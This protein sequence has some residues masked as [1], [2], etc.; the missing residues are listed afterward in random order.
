MVKSGW[1]EE[2]LVKLKRLQ[3]GR[4][5]TKKEIKELL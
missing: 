1:E 4:V 5:K 2:D 3:L